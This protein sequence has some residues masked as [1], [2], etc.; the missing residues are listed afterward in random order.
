MP[1]HRTFAQQASPG[2]RVRTTG[3]DR[4]GYLLLASNFANRVGHPN[5][6]NGRATWQP[7]NRRDRTAPR[8]CV[9]GGTPNGG[10]ERRNGK[11][12]RNCVN[13]VPDG[14]EQ[15]NRDS[16]R[17][18]EGAPQ[19][20][21]SLGCRRRIRSD[22]LQRCFLSPNVNRLRN[23][24]HCI[25]GL[26]A[27]DATPWRSSMAPFRSAVGVPPLTQFRGAVLWRSSVPPLGVPPLAQFRGAVLSRR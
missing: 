10:T 2:L 14:T 7:G 1:G 16:R 12:P 13:G 25:N 20:H 18:G 27:V 24:D 3:A 8:N 4:K 23:H 5:S 26:S 11:A 22:L 9:N 17:T 21:G 6:R 15:W 19:I